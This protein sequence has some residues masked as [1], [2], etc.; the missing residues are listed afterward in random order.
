MAGAECRAEN[1]KTD[2]ANACKMALF[3]GELRMFDVDHREKQGPIKGP[4][5]LIQT[6]PIDE[7]QGPIK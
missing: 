3:H 4:I 6:G 2:C 7:K 5:V 1:K